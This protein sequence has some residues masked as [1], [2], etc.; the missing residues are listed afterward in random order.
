MI[1]LLF[2]LVLSSWSL[3]LYAAASTSNVEL[4][5][6]TSNI[7]YTEPSVMEEKGSLSGVVAQIMSNKAGGISALDVLYS[8]GE[9]DYQGSGT[10]DDIPNELF[11]IRGILGREYMHDSGWKIIPYIGLG[12]RHLN[13]DSSGMVSSTSAHGYERDQVYYYSPVGIHFIGEQF[14]S[15]WTFHGNIEFDYLILGR[16]NSYLSSVQ[17]HEDLSFTQHDGYGSRFSLG[18]SKSVGKRV[19]L[20]LDLFY[21]Y[22]DIEDSTIDYDYGTAMIEPENH[23]KEMGVILSLRI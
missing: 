11:E 3:G 19:S 22:W 2:T 21:K 15:E 18:L 13:D 20:K 8:T 12:Y 4:G 5:F 7:T 9:M 23:S 6:Y 16:N 1:K 14:T 10:I 17:G